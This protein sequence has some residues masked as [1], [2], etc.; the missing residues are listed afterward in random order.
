MGA[1]DVKGGLAGRKGTVWQ[2]RLRRLLP[3]YGHR[4]WIVVADAA[5]PRQSAPGIETVCTGQD[6][7]A[8]LK[9]VLQEIAGTPHVR[10][11]VMLDAELDGVVETDAPGAGARAKAKL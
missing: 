10:A 2:T 5:Y 9:R 7:I 6:Q 11:I 4:N 8:V 3:E 1:K